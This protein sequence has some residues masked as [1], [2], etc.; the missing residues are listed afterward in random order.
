MSIHSA[1]HTLTMCAC[2]RRRRK[3]CIYILEEAAAGSMANF[4]RAAFG[5]D[6]GAAQR[7]ICVHIP[8]SHSLPSLPRSH[9]KA[10]F[11]NE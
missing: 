9:S 5:G 10:N 6:G 3:D 2:V 4:E 7:V 8:S 1:S 11:R